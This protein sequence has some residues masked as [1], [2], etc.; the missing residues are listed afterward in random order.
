MPISLSGD[1]HNWNSS[2]PDEFPTTPMRGR[3]RLATFKRMQHFACT[4]R[5]LSIVVVVVVA[6]AA[7]IVAAAVAF[8]LVSLCTDQKDT[9]TAI[10]PGIVS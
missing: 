3:H 10:D 9:W 8:S 5:S 6:A 1:C 7:A 2:F 4:Q